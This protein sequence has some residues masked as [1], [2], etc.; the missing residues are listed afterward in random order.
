MHHA[1]VAVIGLLTVALAA[2][3]GGGPSE[4]EREHAFL[5]HVKENGSD[6]G[7]IE[8]FESHQCT[9]AES[10]PSYNCDVSAK[11]QDLGRDFGHQLDG[12]YA[13]TKVGG[14]WKVTGRVQ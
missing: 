5:Q 9:K 3:Y 13:F 7:R 11:V 8:D 10:A 6:E 2:C 12:V 4:S 14:A 1:R